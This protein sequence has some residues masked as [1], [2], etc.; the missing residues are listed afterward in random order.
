M[1]ENADAPTVPGCIGAA[2]IEPV[3]AIRTDGQRITR[4]ETSMKKFLASVAIA[5][6]VA[7]PHAFAEDV[8]DTSNHHS[9][10]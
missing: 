10:R 2:T 3:W 4:E 1:E 6:S 8:V 9:Q 7:I 5:M